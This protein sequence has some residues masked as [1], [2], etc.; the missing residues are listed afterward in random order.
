MSTFLLL[1]ASLV[2]SLPGLMNAS[3]TSGSHSSGDGSG[4]GGSGDGHNSCKSGGDDNG[5]DDSGDDTSGDDSSGDGSSS[6]YSTTSSDDSGVSSDSQG[7]AGTNTNGSDNS[8]HNGNDGGK[9]GGGDDGKDGG[10]GDG[11]GGHGGHGGRKCFATLTLNKVVIND[12]DGTATIADFTLTAT[13]STGGV[14]VINGVDPNP[15]T[16]IGLTAKVP[17]TDTYVL[18]ETNIDGYDA[19]GWECSAGTLAGDTLTLAAG[20][21][22]NCTITNNDTPPPPKPTTIT[23]DKVLPGN[24][25]GGTLTPADF[26]LKIDGNNAAQGVAISVRPGSHTISELNRPGYQPAGINCVDLATTTSTE[27]V[28]GSL[29]VA[30]GQNF[31]CFVANEA[32]APMLTLTK[33]VINDNGANLVASDF[34]LQLDGV[35]ADQSTALPVAAGTAHTVGEVATPGY[36]LVS[37]VCTDDDTQA[38]VPYNS[39]VSLVLGQHVTCNLTND[40]DPVDLAITKIGDGLTK[41]AGGASF[42]YNI[43]VD[44]LG[45]RDANVAEPVTVTDQLPAGLTFVTFPAKCSDAGQTLTCDVDPTDLQVADP[46]VV[47][48]VTV[49]ANADAPSATYTNM[50]YVNTADDPACVGNGCVPVCGSASNNVSCATTQVTR[51]AGIAIDKH[52]NVTTSTPGATYS[53]FITVTNPGPSTYPSGNMS[54]TDNLPAGLN[55]ISIDAP[56]PWSCNSGLSIACTYNAVLWPNT[57]AEVITINVMIDPAYSGPPIHN[58]ASAVAVVNAPAAL[59]QALST[60]AVPVDP[61]STVTV[62]ATDDETTTVVRTADLAIDKSVS[63]AAATAGDQFDWNLAI[64]NHGPDA[65]TNVVVSDT[66]PAAFEV[67]STSAAGG[68]ACTNTGNSVQC[69][70]A[71]IA[72]GVTVNAV[73]HVRVAASAAPGVVTNTATVVTDSTDP[74]TA[75]NTDSASITVTAAG[76]EAPVPPAPGGGAGTTPVTLPRTGNAPLRTPLTLASLMFAGGIFSL[77]IARRRRAATV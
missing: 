21:A 13:S 26:Q 55:F 64:T 40:D 50:A 42:D 47:L 33:T 4:D 71:S 7:I 23:V 74:N 31:H 52:A 8:G 11:H 60:D 27:L 65:A 14:K 57:S 35:N 34:Q 6:D 43:T 53:Y 58:V 1:S 67:V 69:T 32:I 63:Q 20:D 17:V 41:V 15:S 3:A 76:S 36:R 22:A 62:T 19:S 24:Q 56:L 48:T 37:I 18:S 16:H 5:S 51:Q 59:A 30:E 39:G 77:V 10:G 61:G 54:M 68:L 73:V 12:N 2:V 28:D 9:D 25:W 49:K 70:A 38:A 66:I 46:A 45:P 44:N 75:D 29:T 72:N